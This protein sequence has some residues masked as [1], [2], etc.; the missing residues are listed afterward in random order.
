MAFPEDVLDVRTEL[1]AGVW[2]DISTHVY[3]RDRIKISGG[4]TDWGARTEPGALTLTLNNISGR[5][6]PRNPTSD[7]YGLIGRNTPVRVS[8]P[9]G[10][11]Y[12][13]LDGEAGSRISCPD[14]AALGITGDIDIRLEA[15][16][17]SWR[18]AQDLAG[19][20]VT[21]GNQRS[22]A[23]QLNAAGHLTLTWSTAGTSATLRDLVSTV[24]VPVPAGRRLAVR[25][26]LD[27]DN[28]A[29][30]H[31]AT[32]WTA[33]S[34][35]GTWTQLGDLVVGTGTTSI[36]DS[37]AIVEV[38]EIAAATSAPQV[39]NPV[40]G[41]FDTTTG[42]SGKIHRFELRSGIGGTAVAN[43]N[44]TIQTPGATSFADTAAAPNTWTVAGGATVDDRDYLVHAEMTS[45]PQRWDV[46]GRDV[47]VPA[48]A[49]GIL[50]R[51]GA[52]SG[53]LRSV[54]YRAM[55]TLAATQPLAYWPCE[56]GTDATQLASGL[57]GGS[58]MSIAG[59][60][61]LASS[62]LFVCSEPLPLVG[63]SRWTGTVPR[64]TTSGGQV[65][66]L[67]AVPS[68]GLTNNAVILRVGLSGSCRTVQ[69]RYSTASS[70]SLQTLAYAGDGTL[71]A[72]TG[73]V[74][75][76]NGKAHRLFITVEQVGSDI[77]VA[78]EY[79]EVGASI[80]ASLPGL[81]V[82][83]RTMGRI[84]SITVDPTG[85][86]DQATIG[87][88]SVHSTPADIVQDLRTELNAFTGEPA[89]RRIERLCAEN[90]VPFRG[91]GDLDATEALG[92]QRA[93]ALTE[94]LH[95]AAE[96]DLGV[97]G[98]SRDR[99]GVEYRPRITLYNQDDAL[100][101]QYDLDSEVADGL[102]PDDD[103]QP[104]GNDLTVSRDRGSSA[105]FEQTEGRLSVA[106][107]PDG[108]G[109]YEGGPVTLNVADDQQLADQA[110]WRVHLNTVDEARYPVVPV[111][112]AAAPHLESLV[113]A[114]QLGDRLT[115]NRLPAR[116]SADPVGQLVQGYRQVVGLYDWDVDFNCSPASPWT[117]GKREESARGRRDTAGCVITGAIS[118][119]ESVI[120]VDTTIGPLWINSLDKLTLNPDFEFDGSSWTVSGGTLT[121]VATPADAPFDGSW[122]GLI[123]P[124]GVSATVAAESSDGAV[125]AGSTYRVHGWLRCARARQVDLTVNWYTAGLVYISTTFNPITVAA[126]VWTRFDFKQVAPATAAV[127]RARPRMASTPPAGDLLWFDVCFLAT[128]NGHAADFPFYAAIGGEKILVRAITGSSDP[129]TVTGR[130]S[131]NG[132]VKSHAAGA[133]FR[134]WQPARRAL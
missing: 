22:W 96:A 100:P 92:P 105:R 51:L 76:F 108:I 42:L 130:R 103:D 78:V 88:I 49:A 45:W 70:G 131:Q 80:S 53:T 41:Q 33:D 83:G 87:H 122:S 27:V 110:S 123:T 54:M 55:V 91:L 95:T 24:P 68:G 81:T 1:L 115:L 5:Y 84:R 128:P 21:T 3:L 99:L 35:G 13:G 23:M 102:Q 47:Y 20:Y 79:M 89:G 25:V 48:E 60:P 37:T 62:D 107:P 126:N 67:L 40:S 14:A 85:T 133:D 31:T 94:L 74:G 17:L 132:V 34:I 18:A 119:T 58:P 50:R 30:G 127:G 32:F 46:S 63:N 64:G 56:D 69:V 6:S 2:T 111:D 26:T 121:R 106:D 4:R 66:F 118:N 109:R 71:L 98:E 59:A 10:E 43:P 77:D 101:L 52:G 86:V 75:P 11:S 120:N 61:S 8:V 12:L 57:P 9:Y 90:A 124:D 28:G 82:T 93:S 16:L 97:L 112:L 114:V 38:G 65:R 73:L 125:V 29:A 134:L 36:F 15:T 113:R 39:S 117:V 116:V 7:L 44:L 129:Q 104:E 72:S 19:K